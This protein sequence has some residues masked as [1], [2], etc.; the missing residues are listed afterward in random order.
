MLIITV[1][2]SL[3]EELMMLKDAD[4]LTL[5]RSFDDSFFVSVSVGVEL[6]E[7]MD[8]WMKRIR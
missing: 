3:M 1:G 6:F 2:L 5:S 4:K 8:Q 7:L